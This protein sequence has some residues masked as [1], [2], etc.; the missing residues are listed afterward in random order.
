MS[1]VTMPPLKTLPPAADIKEAIATLNALLDEFPFVD[2]ASR[3]V[4]VSAMMSTVCR[5]ALTCVP[6]HACSAPA[7][8]SG[9]SY[10]WDVVAG[11]VMGDYMPVIAA[12][13][14]EELMKRM[15]GELIKGV[16]LLS[17]DNV[18]IALGGDV[19][20]HVI[21]RPMY[22]P[23][24][25]GESTM[26]E[27]RNVWTLFATGNNLRLKNDV[28]RRSLS[29]RIDAK[30]ERPELRVFASDPF[31]RVLA[32]R[33]RYVAA[34]LTIATGYMGA[35]SPGRLNRIGEPFAEWSD[36]V[37]SSLVWVGLEDPVATMEAVRAG[38]PA[39]QARIAM[40]TTIANAYGYGYESRR[41]ANQIIADAKDSMIRERGG[42]R[43]T[44]MEALKERIR[45]NPAEDLKAALIAYTDDR[46]TAQ[47]LGN[48]FNVDVGKITEGLTLR[49]ARDNHNKVNYWYIEG[50]EQ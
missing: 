4:S 40:F 6:M 27:R 46:M 38:D 42:Q 26:P 48:K 8:G 7:Y 28:T 44:G 21:E 17:I 33:G 12:D 50:S 25:L 13:N 45:S 29:A 35:G 36:L 11:I 1:E 32:D 14:F 23:R 19:L 37:R 30:V 49:C 20:C 43:R 24:I 10:M 18:S 31:E 9:K 22:I 3:A 16:A 2:E 15:D 39:R 47:Y 41:S 5:A 34:C